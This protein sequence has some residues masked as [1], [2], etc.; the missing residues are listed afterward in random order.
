MPTLKKYLKYAAIIIGGVLM[1][2]LFTLGF[3]WWSRRKDEKDRTEADKFVGVI[4]EI[5]DKLTEANHVA[6]IEIAAARDEEKIVKTKLDEAVK[7]EDKPARRQ[8]LA[9]LYAEVR[10]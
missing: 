6:E 2:V 10:R 4:N 8:R 9:E 3:Q 1:V 7:I 5:G